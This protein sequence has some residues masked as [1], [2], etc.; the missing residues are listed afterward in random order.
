MSIATIRL[1][2]IRM[3]F[4]WCTALTTAW[5]PARGCGHFPLMTTA[6]VS[7]DRSGEYLN[8]QG[9]HWSQKSKRL[10]H[11]WNERSFVKGR[12]SANSIFFHLSSRFGLTQD[13]DEVR[14]WWTVSSVLVPI[15]INLWAISTVSLHWLFMRQSSRLRVEVVYE[16]PQEQTTVSNGA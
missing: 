14:P 7:P 11:W 16:W 6:P 3:C 13:P 15:K 4:Y 9:R 10:S 12:S 8:F 1:A 5:V 2:S